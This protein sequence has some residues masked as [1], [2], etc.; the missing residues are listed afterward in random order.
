MLLTF[1]DMSGT[2]LIINSNRHYHFMVFFWVSRQFESCP[3]EGAEASDP[4]GLKVSLMT[5]QRQGLSWLQWR[6]DQT[7]RGGI[8]G[9]IKL[10]F[11]W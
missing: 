10:I 11:P 3:D 9:M 1:V 6:E 2:V 5:H 8:L 4:D 7:P